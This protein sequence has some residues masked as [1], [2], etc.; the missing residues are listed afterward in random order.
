MGGGFH[1]ISRISLFLLIGLAT[2]CGQNYKHW[3]N[4]IK[5]SSGANL[6]H[7]PQKVKEVSFPF[8]SQAHKC[9]KKDVEND[10][11]KSQRGEDK[12]LLSFFNGLCNGTYIE[13]AA[14]DGK[15]FINSFSFN[16]AFDWK[17]IL[18]ELVPASY[19]RLVQNR[20]NEIAL[21]HS[22]VCEERQTLHYVEQGATSGIFEFAPPAFKDKWWKDVDI[23]SSRV[24]E[25]EC[26]PMKDILA[27]YL[28]TVNYFDFFSLDVE[29]AELQ[30]LKMITTKW[31]LVSFLWKQM[32]MI[33]KRMRL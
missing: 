24:K 19:E 25:I 7:Q 31:L 29:G 10:L 5:E 28:D 18:I 6:H 23:S 2:L 17:G 20:K 1:N 15:R 4:Q 30:V 9:E 16:T 8:Q 11:L 27:K 12:K 13:M 14:L 21:V 3:I 32:S 33:Q 26:A 22:A